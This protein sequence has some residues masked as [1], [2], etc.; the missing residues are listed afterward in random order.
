MVANVWKY[1][2]QR[3]QLRNKTTI[4]IEVVSIEVQTSVSKV[5]TCIHTTMSKLVCPMSRLVYP[6][7]RLLGLYGTGACS[8]QLINNFVYNLS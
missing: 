1:P 8:E 5:Q 4:S 3:L 6:M 2:P 7:S